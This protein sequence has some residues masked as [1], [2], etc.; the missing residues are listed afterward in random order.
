MHYEKSCFIT[1]LVLRLVFRLVLRIVLCLI[2]RLVLRLF[3][4]L[5]QKIALD[6]LLRIREKTIAVV[7]RSVH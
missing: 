7:H 5:R 1:Y 4:P 3:Y 2:L 6:I